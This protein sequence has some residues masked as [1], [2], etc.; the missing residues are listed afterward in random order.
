MV[1]FTTF[2]IFPNILRWLILFKNEPF[3]CNHLVNSWNHFPGIS[4]NI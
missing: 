1:S 2:V 4:T 3:S